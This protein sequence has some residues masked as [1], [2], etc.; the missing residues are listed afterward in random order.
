MGAYGRWTGRCI[1]LQKPPI[2]RAE[3]PSPPL[4]LQCWQ[5]F[6]VMA[7]E[8]GAVGPRR[9]CRCMF[10]VVLLPWCQSLSPEKWHQRQVPCLPCGRYAPDCGLFLFIVL[11]NLQAIL[12]STLLLFPIICLFS[13]NQLFAYSFLGALTHQ[14][15]MECHLS[16]I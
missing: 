7:L 3:A 2:P 15:L 1:L 4:I 16:F 14:P 5:S 13:S 6:E 10:T 11:P 12:A 8:L 9:D